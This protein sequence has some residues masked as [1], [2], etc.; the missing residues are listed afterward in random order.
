M[1]AVPVHAG[2][3]VTSSDGQRNVLAD[4]DLLIT[5]STSEVLSSSLAAGTAG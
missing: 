5:D 2:D 4:T 3:G 1:I